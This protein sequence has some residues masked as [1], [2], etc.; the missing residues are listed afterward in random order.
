V[1]VRFGRRRFL[2]RSLGISA[3]L[4]GA[5]L[6]GCSDDEPAVPTAGSGYRIRVRAVPFERPDDVV[7]SRLALG[8]LAEQVSGDGLDP[9]SQQLVYSRLFD[10]DPRTS[11][12]YAALATE[13]EVMEP[14]LLR[15]RLRDDVYFHPTAAGEAYPVTAE[16]V[17]RE[18]DQRRAE[19]V[20]VFRDVIESAES[21]GA[22]DLLI[23]L[24]AP[25]SL[26]FEHLSQPTASIRSTATYS[27]VPAPLGSGPFVPQ[28]LEGTELVLKA[29]PLRTGDAEPL[30]SE[31]AIWRAG[32]ASDLDALFVQGGLDVREH[33]DSVSRQ[34]AQGRAERVELTRP[35]QAMRGLALS[36]L[37]PAAEA[38]SSVTAFRDSRVRHALSIAVDRTALGLVDGAVISGPIGPSFEGDALP[39]VELDAHPLYQHNPEEAVALLSAAGHEA[40]SFRLSH[41]DTPVMLQIGQGIV[42]QLAAVG[43][44]ARLVTRPPAEF[45]TAFLAGDFDAAFVELERLV[46][47]DIG[48]RL[49]TS[50]GLEGQRSPWGYSNPVFDAKVTQTL[51][52]VDP[53][54]R[55]RFSREAQRLL[56]DDV[57]AL[58]PFHAPIEFAS[59]SPGLTGYE[60]GAYDFN[61][62][63]LSPQWRVPAELEDAP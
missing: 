17:L 48:L 49:H 53:E 23:R 16:D 57:P 25:F 24:R 51:S 46:S 7:R 34:T 39:L 2:Q 22:G 60:F 58:L 38:S 59:T 12:V 63:A 35:R 18:F 9:I 20:F 26:L 5:A 62:S 29:N 47:P 50:G 32:Q 19:G 44:T 52:Q 15:V 31:V 8:T 40:L 56:L 11:S 33:P 43:V 14:Q 13:V 4:A 42:E 21:P 45:Q 37:G 61:L 27:E 3:G 6:L 55:S 54:L 36:L 30:L 1:T 28:L 41:P 10:L